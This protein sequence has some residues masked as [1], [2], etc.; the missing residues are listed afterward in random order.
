MRLT[1]G[2]MHA[3]ALG[4]DAF[5]RLFSK[6]GIRGTD[7]VKTGRASVKTQEGVF[8]RAVSWA[9]R[10]VGGRCPVPRRRRPE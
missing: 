2:F 4:E 10:E 9:E 7:R 6:L 1:R 5:A 8:R 3:G